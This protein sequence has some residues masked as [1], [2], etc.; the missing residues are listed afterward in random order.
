MHIKDATLRESPRWNQFRVDFENPYKL[1]E[2]ECRE[3]TDLV[4]DDE[5]IIFH[6]ET[7]ITEEVTKSKINQG[8]YVAEVEKRIKKVY[9]E[10]KTND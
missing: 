8:K 10:W 4:K 1:S 7:I 9:K 3:L 2:K 6:P 5:I